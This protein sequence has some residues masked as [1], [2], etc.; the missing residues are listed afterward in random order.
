MHKIQGMIEPGEN[1]KWPP[2]LN[3]YIMVQKRQSGEQI[4]FGLIKKILDKNAGIIIVL[5]KGFEYPNNDV[6]K[7]IKASSDPKKFMLVTEIDGW[8][9]T[10]ET[11]IREML[12][13][14]PSYS[15]DNGSGPEIEQELLY[16]NTYSGNITL[17]NQY[18][19][20]STDNPIVNVPLHKLIDSQDMDD[21]AFLMRKD[22]T[23]DNKEILQDELLINTTMTG[24]NIEEYLSAKLIEYRPMI[25]AKLEGSVANMIE[26]DDLSDSENLDGVAVKKT[27]DQSSIIERMNKEI[28][29]PQDIVIVDSLMITN[30]VDNSSTLQLEAQKI[31]RYLSEAFYLSGDNAEKND[32]KLYDT[33]RF[34]YYNGYLHIFRKEIPLKEIITHKLLGDSEEDPKLKILGPAEYNI[35]IRHNVLKYVLFQNEIQKNM[36]VDQQL[37]KET[38]LV[39]SQEYIIAL[40]PEPRYQIWCVIRLIKLWYGDIDLQNNIRKIKL[41]VNQYRARVDK[42]YNIHNGIRFSIGIY[43]RYGKASAAIVLKKVMYYFSLYFQAIGWKS[44]PPSY[45]KVVNDLVSYTNCD[46][47]L[48]LYYR[49]IVEANGE[50]NNVFSKNFTTMVSPGNNTD[51]LEQYVRLK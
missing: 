33:L 51:I 32:D 43:P 19:A 31:K 8:R 22:V 26:T 25:I 36:S 39:L 7:Y 38:E 1:P 47:S 17:K 3:K 4:Y 21:F 27:E 16:D 13:S 6:I 37:L 24:Y 30:F 18:Y 42:K 29:K 45:F 2:T 40:T 34:I 44:N 15:V 41:L 5:V 10:T 23:Y 46:Q 35:P 28:N 49:R 9:Y 20:S 14:N 12:S 48:K 50:P 11:K